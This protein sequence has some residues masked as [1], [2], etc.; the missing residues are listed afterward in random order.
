MADDRLLD[1]P[2]R[3]A[4]SWWSEE[5]QCSQL[6]NGGT[7]HAKPAQPL[8]VDGNLIVMVKGCCECFFVLRMRSRRAGTAL[9]VRI[10]P[11]AAEDGVTKSDNLIEPQACA[12]PSRLRCF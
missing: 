1:S 4:K 9:S 10:Q 2:T 3:A 11:G 8:Q 5:L 12:D 6:G 7:M